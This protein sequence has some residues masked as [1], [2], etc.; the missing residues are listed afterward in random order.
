MINQLRA[1]GIMLWVTPDFFTPRIP[2]PTFL[3]GGNPGNLAFY[4][5]SPLKALLERLVDFDLINAKQTRFSVGAVNIKTG[6]LT[7][8]DNMTHN[9]GPAHVMASCSLPPGTFDLKAQG[10]E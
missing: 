8:F 7:Y 4:E 1:M 5:I 9:V 10:R 3:P 6:N 2:P